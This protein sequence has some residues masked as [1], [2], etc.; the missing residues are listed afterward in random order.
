M[1]TG[2]R[3]NVS[4]KIGQ[5]CSKH[6]YVK[7]FDRNH[8]SILLFNSKRKLALFISADVY[9]LQDNRVYLYIQSNFN[10]SNTDGSFTMARSNLFSS[11]YGILP[12]VQ[13]KKKKKKKK[14][15]Y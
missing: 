15:K 14:H 11:P 8:L 13:K 7:T 6:T 9:K 1:L 4:L 3:V 2:I 12:T 5:N 10:S